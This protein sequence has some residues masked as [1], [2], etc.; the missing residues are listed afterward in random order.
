MFFS[1]NQVKFKSLSECC[2]KGDVDW[3]WDEVESEADFKEFLFTD[4][5]D[6]SYLI[7]NAFQSEDPRLRRKRGLDGE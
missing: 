2:E 3:E 6:L 1:K 7:H 5:Y 4:P